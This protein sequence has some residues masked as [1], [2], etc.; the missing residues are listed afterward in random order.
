MGCVLA[1]RF[2][3]NIKGPAAKLALTVEAI[4]GIPETIRSQTAFDH[5]TT[6]YQ[7]FRPPKT[8]G[9]CEKCVAPE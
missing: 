9:L 8:S 2:N 5:S 3:E 6:V 4:L 1:E 7:M